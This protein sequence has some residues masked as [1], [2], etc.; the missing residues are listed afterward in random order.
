MLVNSQNT[1]AEWIYVDEGKLNENSLYNTKQKTKY[2]VK[3]SI[4]KVL[5]ILKKLRCA[6]SNVVKVSNWEIS[7]LNYWKQQ[8]CSHFL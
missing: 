8:G 5:I 1:V 4:M 6:C 2:V 3:R 7:T